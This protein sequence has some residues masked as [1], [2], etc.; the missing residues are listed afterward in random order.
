[1]ITGIIGAMNV[2][3]DAL[4]ALIK[5]P[6][7]ETV[8]GVEFVHGTI[9]GKKVVVAQCGIG[10]VFAALCAQTMILRYGVKR[11]INTGVA[12]GLSD[13]LHL[14]DIAIS[15]AVVQHDMDTSP[16][17]DPVGLISGINQV[18]L[19]ASLPLAKQIAEIASSMGKHYEFGVIAS[20]DQFIAAPDKKEWL[21][22]TFGPIACEMEG[23]AIGH[24]CYV[25]GV[26]FVIIRSISDH[27][28]EDAGTMEYPELCRHA[29]AQ[30][31]RLIE[32]FFAV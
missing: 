28:S 11:I 25:N 2:E 22:R 31:Q 1:M 32:A 14:L 18:E 8:S 26:D 29:A 15:T 23:A 5:D 20:G 27:A 13:H 9:H 17:G 4:K 16:L 24:T 10:K 19:P 6:E 7:K 12:G 3:T 21:I 30:S